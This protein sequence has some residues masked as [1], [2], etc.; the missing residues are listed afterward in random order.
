MVPKMSELRMIRYSFPSMVISV[1][2]YLPYRISSPTL[3]VTGLS[4]RPSP[5]AMTFPFWGF[6][7][8]VSGMKM[9]DA[10][11]S[12][13][14][15]G[16]TRTRSSFGLKLIFAIYVMEVLVEQFFWFCHSGTHLLCQCER[17]CKK[18]QF[19]YKMAGF[20]GYYWAEKPAT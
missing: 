7:L 2:A 4:L 5:T 20:V 11:F 12:S 3:T 1:P 16:S 13:A 19:C 15:A 9:P 8:E 6:S 18:A 10:V 17:G 14:S